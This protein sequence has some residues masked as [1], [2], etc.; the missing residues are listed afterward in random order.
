VRGDPRRRRG[1]R[2]TPGRADVHVHGHRV[3]PTW[4]A[5]SA[6]RRGRHPALARRD[7]RTQIGSHQGEVVH[8]RRR[9]LRRSATRRPRR[10]ARSRSSGGSPTTAASTGSRPRCGSGSTRPRR[11]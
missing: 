3:R 2:R 4:C 8:D 11:P 6:T 9:V 5:R 7:A 1:R 10:A